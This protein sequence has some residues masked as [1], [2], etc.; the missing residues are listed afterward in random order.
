MLL[1]ILADMNVTT[2]MLIAGLAVISGA[3]AW[4]VLPRRVDEVERRLIALETRVANESNALTEVK[5]V[6]NI[7]RARTDAIAEKLNVN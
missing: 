4:I 2:E 6:L 1:T 7:V 5:A 3:A